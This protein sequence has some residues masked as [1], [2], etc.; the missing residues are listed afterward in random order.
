MSENHDW[1]KTLGGIMEKHARAS[2]AERENRQ[3]EEFIASVVT[4]ALNELADELRKHERIVMIRPAP[5]AI[6]ISVRNGETE[7]IA[8]TVLR[9]SAPNAVVAYAEVRLRKG[10]RF[11]KIEANIRE[12]EGQAPLEQTTGDDVIECFLKYYGQ[13]LEAGTQ[14]G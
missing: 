6:S 11:V 2:R 7:E 9:R 3:F 14:D 5:A 1:R 4:P 8:F 13:V 12:G 10:Q